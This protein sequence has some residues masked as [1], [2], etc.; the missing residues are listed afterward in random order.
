MVSFQYGNGKLDISFQG[1]GLADKETTAALIT[2]FNMW[3]REMS[4]DELNFKTCSSRGNV[5][6]WTRTGLKWGTLTEKGSSTQ[7]NNHVVACSG[8]VYI[9]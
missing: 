3:S 9:S 4:V 5:V 7:I 1:G 6:S 8:K 2:E